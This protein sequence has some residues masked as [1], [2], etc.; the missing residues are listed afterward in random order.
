MSTRP[1]I[2]EFHNVYGRAVFDLY[3]DKPFPYLRQGVDR[4]QPPAD[5]TAHTGAACI[6]AVRPAPDTGR[7]GQARANLPRTDVKSAS[8]LMVA[9]GRTGMDTAAIS[10]PPGKVATPV[11]AG[12]RLVMEISRQAAI[13]YD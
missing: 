5:H 2:V 9:K 4:T 11:G 6:F 10:A 7:L 12:C 8:P 1:R 13:V 3:A